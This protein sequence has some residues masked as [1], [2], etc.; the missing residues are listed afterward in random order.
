LDLYLKACAAKPCLNGGT[1]EELEKGQGWSWACFCA[2][3]YSGYKCADK[4]HQ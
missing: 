1:C 3:G 2:P 4:N